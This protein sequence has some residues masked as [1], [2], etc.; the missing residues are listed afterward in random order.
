MGHSVDPGIL[1]SVKV[2]VTPAAQSVVRRVEAEGRDGLVMILGTGCCDSTAPFL[3]DRY[4]PGPDVVEVGS[5]GA[6]PILAHRW[7]ADL[8]ADS[9][10]LEIDVDEGFPNDS[11]SLESEYDARFTLRIGPRKPAVSSAG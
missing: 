4:Y 11:F 6:I 7:M 8:Y 9:E 3:Y 2:T 5:A 10:G 1:G